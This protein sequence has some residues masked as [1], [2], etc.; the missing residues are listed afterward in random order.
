MGGAASEGQVG[1]GQAWPGGRE[2]RVG[3]LRQVGLEGAE[4][5]LSRVGRRFDPALWELVYGWISVLLQTHLAGLSALAA[6]AA[7]RHPAAAT[8][9]AGGERAE[10]SGGA[11]QV[12]EEERPPS[13]PGSGRAWAPVAHTS[14]SSLDLVGGAASA[15]S[16]WVHSCAAPVC[17][18]GRVCAA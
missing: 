4:R 10:I 14:A 5:L 6:A 3:G 1:E 13:Q 17:A 11:K 9:P 18:R 12:E 7:A 2:M 16:R 15:G 8:G